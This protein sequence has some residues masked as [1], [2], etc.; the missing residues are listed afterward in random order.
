MAAS[1]NQAAP[2]L[3]LAEHRELFVPGAQVRFCGLRVHALDCL[4]GA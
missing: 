1:G 2:D 4:R 3:D